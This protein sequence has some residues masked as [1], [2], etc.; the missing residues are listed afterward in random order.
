MVSLSL[1]PRHYKQ[2]SGRPSRRSACAASRTGKSNA[3]ALTA[4]ADDSSH[5]AHKQNTKH[6][7]K[8]T[9]LHLTHANTLAHTHTQAQKHTFETTYHSRKNQESARRTKI[10]TQTHAQHNTHTTRTKNTRT[11]EDNTCAFCLPLP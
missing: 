3:Q 7:D 4:C 8:H 9:H 1:D 11:H 6:T 2:N 10:H 5:S